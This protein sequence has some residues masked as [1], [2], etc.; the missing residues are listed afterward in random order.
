[1][2]LAFDA[3]KADFSG[4]STQDALFLSAVL[5][6]AYVD[7]NEEGTEAAAA[8]GAVVAIR[9]A[10]LPRPPAVFRADHPFLFL[11]VHKA[12]RSVLFQGRVVNP[13]G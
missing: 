7:L 9:A 2:P 13:H 1:M 11:I 3:R 8:T 4:M 5:H 12:T 10:M 6:K